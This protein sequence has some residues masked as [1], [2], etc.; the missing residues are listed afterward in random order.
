[1]AVN[2]AL[3]NLNCCSDAQDLMHQIVKE[4]KIDLIGV[5]EPYVCPQSSLWTANTGETAAVHTPGNTRAR[6][7]M[8]KRQHYVAVEW[9]GMG[10]ATCYLPPSMTHEEYAVVLHQ[11]QIDLRTEKM[12]TWI[13]MGDMNAKSTYWGYEKSDPKGILMEEWIASM[14]FR[15]LNRGE[16]T[17]VRWQGASTVDIV[18][19]TP[20]LIDRVAGWWVRKDILSLSDHLYVTF[21]IA[22]VAHGVRD[23]LPAPCFPRWNMKQM[24]PDK[25]RAA[26]L[27]MTWSKPQADDSQQERANMAEESA[28]KLTRLMTEASDATMPRIEHNGC[29]GDVYWWNASV[30]RLRTQCNRM[31]RKLKY[32]A[33]KRRDPEEMMHR[34][35]A[36]R[37]ARKDFKLEIKKAKEACW[38]RMLSTLEA[39][40]WG[41]PYRIVLRKLK[42]K[43][44]SGTETMERRDIEAAITALFPTSEEPL[45][46]NGEVEHDE[47]YNITPGELRAVIARTK[48][49]KAPGPDGITAITWKLAAE[50]LQGDII[51]CF[52]ACV[53]TGT[54][55]RC[56]KRAR[57]VLVPKQTGGD[58]GPAAYR[59]LCML[60]E[61]GKIFEKVLAGRICQ[62]LAENGDLSPSQYGFR[63]GLS[64]VDA[65]I[66][67]RKRTTRVTERGGYVI[68]VGLD[69]AN[70]FGSLPWSRIVVAA[71]RL[72]LPEYLVA[73]IR[74]YLSERRLCCASVEGYMAETEVGC[75][76]PQGSV[77]GP[78]MWNLVYDE[79]LRTP[80]PL[81][82]SM[83][84]YADDT[85]LLAVG[86]GIRDA[87][88]MAR[89]VAGIVIRG[90]HALG[91]RVAVRK[92]EAV[93][94]TPKKIK[95]VEGMGVKIGEEM[96]PLKASMKYLGVIVD[97]KWSF[98]DH[99]EYAT[100]KANAVASALG[101]LMPNMKGPNTRVRRLYASVVQSV[102]LYAVPAWHMVF[103]RS[104][105]RWA[106]MM[107]VQRRTGI[108][109]VAGYRTISEHAACLLGGI[110]PLDLMAQGYRTRYEWRL[111]ARNG[112]W[113]E[114]WGYEEA[115]QRMM[116]EV[117]GQ[118]EE[119]TAP[120]TVSGV[121]TTL[122]S[123]FKGNIKAWREG[124]R[125]SLTYWATQ[126]LT[127]HGSFGVY[128]HNI[129][130]RPT[131]VC[132][133][134]DGN[135]VDTVEHTLAECAAWSEH[136]DTLHAKTNARVTS[137]N[138]IGVMLSSRESWR[139]VL[140]YAKVVLETKAKKE[141][142][143]DAIDF[144]LTGKKHGRRRGRPPRKQ[145]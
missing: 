130:R 127:G 34:L 122:R 11:M 136:R 119:R 12:S 135:N 111:K 2:V 61:L 118:W 39:D 82:C 40:P 48:S 17:C 117:Y 140:E 68:A 18:L 24:D 25:L 59:P 80:L 106:A 125:G 143:M 141:R 50:V 86:D 60:D 56:W 22:G 14:D 6:R 88:N 28:A 35:A 15:V 83:L 55:P 78:L 62:H 36:F 8:L 33:R 108:R 42:K 97:R 20:G 133:H 132:E 43:E 10:I 101:S 72:G 75:G 84:C 100:K 46:R 70:A 76:V 107:A 145:Q 51:A 13:V 4:Q 93:L 89:H 85:V 116:K 37:K 5:T 69:I 19:V 137:E 3:I 90:I 7:V 139:A 58:A 57:L 115:R 123:A 81:G 138:I 73:L 26:L 71:E 47:M 113:E 109:V 104:R 45:A 91:L 31:R 23:P 66:E 103:L 74:S 94:F 126:M 49:G 9:A 44:Y 110:P 128:L 120:R 38:D 54:F 124:N 32:H 64:T 52:N 114:E 95:W 53:R 144:L 63:R 77:L 105:T 79:V 27:I 16:P 99:M 121:S 65:I 92:T 87:Q 102:L 129:G 1:M 21:G 41:R 131:E 142:E 134:C 30:D 96:T 112:T 98:G 67:F 29:K